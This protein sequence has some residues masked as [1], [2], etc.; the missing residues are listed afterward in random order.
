MDWPNERYVRVYTRDTTTW[1]LL[2]WRA[3]TVL[4]HMFRKVDRAGV[5]EVGEDGVLGL[6]AMIELP[7]EIVEPGLKQLLSSRSPTVIEAD[8]SYVIPH[9]IEAQEC[10]QTDRQRAKESRSRRRE[11]ALASRNVTTPS[12]NEANR[13]GRSHDVTVCHSEPSQAKPDCPGPDRTHADQLLPPEPPALQLEPATDR[14]DADVRAA[15]RKLIRAN[16]EAARSRAGAARKVAIKPLL[17]FDRGLDTDL[18]DRI[19]RA[20]TLAELRTLVDQ[21]THAI[22][23]AEFEVTHGGRDFTWFTGAIF[24]GG[25]FARLAGMTEAEAKRP[26]GKPGDNAAPA[27]VRIKTSDDDMPYLGEAFGFGGPVT[28]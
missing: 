14:P 11:T 28:S 15:A 18:G 3:R 10:A 7:I 16:L 5:L 2:D 8:G 1:K 21:A 17:A 26:R 6:A 25:N 23:M 9:F 20:S 13:H 4:L 24:S 22:A 27:P 12:R 19:L